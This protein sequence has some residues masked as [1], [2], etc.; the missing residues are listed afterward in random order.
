MS[1]KDCIH[2]GICIFHHTGN[3][4]MECVHFKPTADVVE[5]VR[6]GEWIYTLSCECLLGTD[7]PLN[8]EC[9]NCGELAT[10]PFS[11]C[12]NCGAKMDGERKEQ[13]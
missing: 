13:G 12:P 5:V 7:A 2:Y 3:E 1:C 9:S 4:Y 10:D 8:Y 11:F 6:C